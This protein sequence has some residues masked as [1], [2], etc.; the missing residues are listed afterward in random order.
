MFYSSIR[1]TQ[2]DVQKN[3]K[4]FFA[5]VELAFCA[6]IFDSCQCPSFPVTQ[7]LS[8]E[9]SRC[10]T[11][12]NLIMISIHI[13]NLRT[14]IAEHSDAASMSGRSLSIN[15]IRDDIEMEDSKSPLD[16]THRE[17]D[18]DEDS[19]GV[20]FISIK[21]TT[22]DGSIHEENNSDYGETKPPTSPKKF[23]Q[24]SENSPKDEHH[25]H[26]DHAHHS[27]VE[28]PFQEFGKIF[29]LIFIWIL[30]VF[31]LTSTPEKRIEKRQLTIP[32]DEPK[33]FN[34]LVQPQSTLVQIT[35][36]APFL[37]DPKERTYKSNNT[38]E[39]TRNKDNLMVIFLRTQADKIL[40]PNKTFYIYKPEEIDF[41]NATRIEFTFDIGED[42]FEDLREDDV[43]QAVILS[44]FS[45]S[46]DGDKQEIPITFSVD[47]API[48]KPIGVLF[49][50]FTL[51][52]LY[53]L[54]VWEVSCLFVDLHPKSFYLIDASFRSCTERL[55]PSLPALYPL[56]C[57]RL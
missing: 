29:F 35:L 51:I 25:D 21:V 11:D 56:R 49:A 41:V 30:M 24:I 10:S 36:Q 5:R 34:F 2:T 7:F 8:T 44:N 57:W 26:H 14:L 38:F 46:R 54:I 6:L 9:I 12:A 39:D 19:D 45:K 20:Q 55:L 47:F 33:Y 18:S 52:L 22:V 16:R 42:N 40:T 32:I 1:V 50:A 13:R 48:N 23:V 53:A 17:D 43:I 37:P 31:F 15:D 28:S 3:F 27:K 4:N